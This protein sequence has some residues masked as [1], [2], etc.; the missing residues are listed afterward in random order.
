MNKL[1]ILKLS[2]SLRLILELRKYLSS[3]RKKQ[4]LILFFLSILSAI[5]ESVSLSLFLPFAQIIINPEKLYSFIYSNK[6]LSFISLSESKI[7]LF[8]SIAFIGVVIF[9]TVIR[10]FNLW[11]ISKFV[12][13]ASSELALQAYRK[14]LYQPYKVHVSRNSSKVI[15]TIISETDI[16]VSAINSFLLFFNSIV[17]TFFL[18]ITLLIINIQVT[19]AIFLFLLTGYLVIS[20]YTS[21][22][23]ISNSKKIS[24]GYKKQMQVLKEG[25]GSI[26]EIL[27]SSNQTFYSNIYKDIDY[28]LRIKLTNNKFIG[29]Y[30]RFL[31]EGI[32]LIG[33]C[34]GLIVKNSQSEVFI[35]LPILITAGLGIQKLLPLLQQIYL[36]Y[37]QIKSSSAS[38]EAL[39]KLLSQSILK[40]QTKLVKN[41]FKE[42]IIF[43]NVSFAYE[44]GGRKVI[45][46]LS[47]EIFKGEKIGIKGTTGSGKTTMI[48][49]LMGL[50]SPTEGHIYI[51]NYDINLKENLSVMKSWRKSLAHV[52]QTNILID[53]S[54]SENIALGTPFN[55]IDFDRVKSSAKK[56]KINDYIESLRLGYNTQIG[57]Q[58]VK[59]SGGE[60]QRIAIARAFYK[61]AK[62]LILDEA[63]SA[64]DQNTE[65]EITSNLD[66]DL[67][68][69]TIVVIAHRLET[70]KNCTRIF[71][72]KNGNLINIETTKVF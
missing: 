14:T 2:K 20:F 59:I 15:S 46:N 9:S 32:I 19:V 60:R 37:S 58:G 64:L 48:D 33:L 43:R 6:L 41:V 17:L 63:T 56:A 1:K 7:V 29:S 35:F 36:N 65:K 34:V 62:I 49:L 44:P 38:I 3:K 25:L 67:K 21:N 27:L 53:S 45:K 42:K 26:K 72:F 18:I 52:P 40:N 51:D 16:C 71:E 47:F 30:P 57:E 69:L 50:L 39:L 4:V 5:S 70:L 8:F 12:A 10:I 28:N 23:L 22:L 68:D 13:S 54:I 11:F 31:F 55:K 61:N 66:F 24:Q